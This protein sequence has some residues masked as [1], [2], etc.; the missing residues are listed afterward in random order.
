[1]LFVALFSETAII[2]IDFQIHFCY[3]FGLKEKET[4]ITLFDLL[5]GRNLAMLNHPDLF[6]LICGFPHYSWVIIDWWFY[7]GC[8]R[9][10]S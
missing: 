8:S 9:P 1:M 3:S 6:S 10:F 4:S 5:N 7:C 2:I